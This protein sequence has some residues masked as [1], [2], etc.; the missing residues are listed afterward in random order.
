VTK[1]LGRGKNRETIFPEKPNSASKKIW[2][3][4][5]LKKVQ[6]HVFYIHTKIVT[7]KW[8]KKKRETI[9]PETHE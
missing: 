4:N 9:F 3:K 5:R 1:K 2:E 8:G 7:K 6:K